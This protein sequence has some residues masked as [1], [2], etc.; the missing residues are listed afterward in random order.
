MIYTLTLSPALDYDIYIDNLNKSELNSAKKINFRA[1]GKGINVSI[2]LKNLG[3]Q[4]SALGFLA[5]FV[6]DFIKKDLLSKGIDSDFI[7]IDGIN[8]INVK[9]NDDISETEISGVSPNIS[10][11]NIESLK[12]KLSIL[13][14]KDILVLSGS[15]PNGLLQNTYYQLSKLTKAKVVLDTRGEYLLE[16]I[17]NN[18]LIK[19][20][21][22]ELE[23]VFKIKF[24]DEI[25]IYKYCEKILEKGV[26]NIIVSLGKEGALLIKKG[27]MYKSNVPKGDYVNSIGAGD[28]MVAGFIYGYINNFSDEDILKFAVACGSATTYSYNLATKEM[29]DCLLDDIDIREVNLCK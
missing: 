7:D 29:V 8:R 11:D 12:S 14:E 21:I 15:I 22:S 5:G 23:N 16:N 25:Q 17:Y 1:G 19:P 3:I 9:I 6:G 28:S 24:K 26:L 20:N 13:N 18:L 4:N 27:K 2:M 10:N